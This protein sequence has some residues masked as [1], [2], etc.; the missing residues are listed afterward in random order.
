[1]KT[2]GDSLRNARETKNLTQRE[3]SKKTGINNKTISNYENDVSSPDPIALKTFADVYETSV[4]YLLGRS[5]IRKESDPTIKEKHCF[6]VDG[7]PEEAL[8]QVEEYIDL[9]KLKYKKDGSK[10]KKD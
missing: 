8:K 7:L 3:V 5:F 9:L 1:L 10:K 2:L 4:D 6:D